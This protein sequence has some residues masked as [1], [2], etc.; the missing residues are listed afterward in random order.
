MI[1]GVGTYAMNSPRQML[2]NKGH[3][4]RTLLC[5]RSTIYNTFSNNLFKYANPFNH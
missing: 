2:I 3:H 1:K 4:K 5:L